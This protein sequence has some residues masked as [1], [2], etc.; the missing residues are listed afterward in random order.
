MGAGGM[1]AVVGVATVG[2]L[3]FVACPSPS[4]PLPAPGDKVGVGLGAGSPGIGVSPAP[5]TPHTTGMGRAAESASGAVLQCR[6]SF[7]AGGT[8]WRGTEGGV[9]RPGSGKGS[10]VE[11]DKCI[12]AT[13]C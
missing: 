4:T 9:C 12:L 1:P 13:L 3:R 11:G 10:R 6:A 7:R 2:G 8:A 5:V